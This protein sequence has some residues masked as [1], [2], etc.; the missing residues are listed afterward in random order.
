MTGSYDYL[1]VALSVLI[2]MFASYAALD[3][4]GRVTAG[5]G[6]ARSAW[7]TG[8]AT[9]MGFGIWSMHY[10]GMLAFKLP[11]PVGYD[12]PTV[13]VS[14]LAAIF[15]SAVAL[16]V[17]SRQKMGPVHALI[18][19]VIMGS[20]I[21][22]M[23][24]IGMAAMRLPAV[25]RFDPRLVT[26]SVVFAI[27]IS[28]VAL[29]FAFHFRKET[30]GTSWQKIGS[31]MVMGAAIPVMHYTGMAA[32]SFIPSAVASDLSHAISISSLSTAGIAIIT[33]VV[34]G[35]SLLT[36]SIDRRFY[37]QALE[38]ESSEQRYR[39]LF[40][41]NLAGVYRTTL[42][43]RILDCNDACSQI[44]GYTSREEHL[45]NAE[46]EM[47]LSFVEQ[48]EF[49]ATLRKQR[50]LTNFERCLRR[51]DGSPVWVLENATL[52]ED[53]D[54][55]PSVIQ[56]T[57]ID[58]TE[59][60]RAEE[61]LQR[62]RDELEIRVR[63]RTAE[64]SKSNEELKKEITERER[65]EEALRES[66]VQLSRKNRYEVIISTLI[67]S[68]YQSINL[69]DVLENA[70]DVLSENIDGTDSVSI[71]LVEGKE[72]ILK[73]H[74][75]FPDW[76][77]KRLKKIPY[78]KGATWK[79]II[80]EKPIY[81]TNVDQDTALGPAGRELGIKSYL[82]TPI[83]YE[84]NT[85]GTLNINSL[86]KNTFGEEELKLLEIVAQ[87]IEGA[88]NNAKRAEALHHAQAELAHVARVA[89]LGE[90]IASIAHEINQPLAAVV[91][92]ASACLRWLAAQNLDEARQSASLVIADG[93]RASEI[94]GRIR[95][96]VKKA[97]PHKEWL[98]INETIREIIALTHSEVQGNHVSLQ[99]Q[100]SGDLPL[101]LGDRIQL[102]QVILNLMMNAIEAMSAVSE[103][104]RGLWVSS[105]RVE[106]G[107]ILI[108][109]RDSGPGLDPKGL[110][111]L[112]DAFYT[113][114]PQGLGMGLAISRSIIE[115]HGG[116]LW[117][118]ANAPH[119]AVFQF[120]LPIVSER[121]S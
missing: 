85:I 23:H 36:S 27:M 59:R 48:E 54:S 104:P 24:Y 72:A 95:A 21:A 46:H 45:S 68:V 19:S 77:V 74:R 83:R 118:T 44:L 47:C 93:H 55:T 28:L 80:E 63:E 38:L 17:V 110:D 22:T 119:G 96:L 120:T 76:F 67:Q 62:A 73:A 101:I 9:V 6:W 39:Q 8:G 117:A 90:I 98:D 11:V 43:G 106:S 102:Q 53:K 33:L 7:L 114:K 70:V 109:V 108:A 31:A 14:L 89:T 42:D 64:L 105:E 87:Q 40:E 56:G 78:P 37:T 26:L 18:G 113:T 32:A 82:I 52:L 10:I 99:T 112:F 5:S 107:D 61:E 69:Q 12:W 66:L 121:V 116:R 75:G 71:F 2:A 58:I 1:L 4:A 100:L 84:G 15:A 94:I 86:E 103:G 51:N 35:L 97:P 41:R 30:K 29:W 13:L 60:K 34:L 111:Y 88:I 3:L 50:A 16:Y 79:A 65:A 115:A 92:N 91:N 81:C 25:C 57:L 49:L 20:G